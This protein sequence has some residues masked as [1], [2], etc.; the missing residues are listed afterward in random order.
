M[1]HLFQLALLTVLAIGAQAQR[2]DS[3]IWWGISPN[4]SVDDRLQITATADGLVIE[5]AS[6]GKTPVPW[7]PIAVAPDGMITFR[8]GGQPCDLKRTAYGTYEGSCGER[9]LTLARNGNPGGFELVAGDQDLEILAKARQMLSGPSVWNRHDDRVCDD[10]RA[11]ESWSLFCAL[12]QASVDVTGAD[13]PL[14]PVMQEVRAAAVE[15]AHRSFQRS[16]QDF[17]NA[18]STTYADI[19]KVFDVSERRLRTMKACVAGQPDDAT[20]LAGSPSAGGANTQPVY[21]WVERMGHTV[22]GQTFLFSNALGP[23]DQRLEVP[24]DM[25]ATSA[26]VKRRTFP[27]DPRHP[28][29]ATGTLANGHRWRFAG[30]CGE[31]FG[32]RDSPS[33][34]ADYFDRLIDNAYFRGPKP[35]R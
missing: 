12:Y 14:R 24:D 16:L 25:L 3:G 10:S 26:S 17:N 23:P 34:A 35:V 4:Q 18:E 15:V 9:P 29:D 21:Y 20:L 22:K 1:R 11:K 2:P 19:V 32:Y 28:I 5:S 31:A 30:L 27:D 7:G 33:E 6:L 13:L 8:R